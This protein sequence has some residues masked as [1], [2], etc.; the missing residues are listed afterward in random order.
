M[1]HHNEASK[2]RNR[3]QNWQILLLELSEIYYNKETVYLTS[4][5]SIWW[6]YFLAGTKISKWCNPWYNEHDRKWNDIGK[7]SWW[8][9]QWF[10]LEAGTWWRI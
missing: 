1:T 5:C 2:S 8:D 10:L 4:L 7:W 6:R 3:G 9:C